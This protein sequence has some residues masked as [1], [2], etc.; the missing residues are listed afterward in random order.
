MNFPRKRLTNQFSSNGSTRLEGI[1]EDTVVSMHN[2]RQNNK[3]NASIN[4]ILILPIR[5]VSLFQNRFSRHHHHHYASSFIERHMV[6]PAPRSADERHPSISIFINKFS[7]REKFMWPR[8]HEAERYENTIKIHSFKIIPHSGFVL[9]IKS[10]IKCWCCWPLPKFL[11]QFRCD[12]SQMRLS[13]L[14]H[15]WR[16]FSRCIGIA[17][18]C[19][20]QAA[21]GI[22]LRSIV[23]MHWCIDDVMRQR[24]PMKNAVIQS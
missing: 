22:I 7:M 18:S 15:L 1:C 11:P 4:E 6:V 21:S 19:R 16:W 3:F 24:W 13:S 8:W 20:R 14:P 10:L 23:S 9:T 12:Q 2:W 5:H 17:C